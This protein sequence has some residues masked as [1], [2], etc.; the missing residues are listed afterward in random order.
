MRIH[1]PIPFVFTGGET[2]AQEGKRF[3][4]GPPVSQ[5]G[6]DLPQVVT[7]SDYLTLNKPWFPQGLTIC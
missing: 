6:K 3:S 2:E 4:S 5:Q 1:D 7:V